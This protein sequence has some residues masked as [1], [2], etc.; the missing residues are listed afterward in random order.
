[1]DKSESQASA[2]T[3]SH[4]TVDQVWQE[5]IRAARGKDKGFPFSIPSICCLQLQG[6]DGRLHPP[7]ES[8]FTLWGDDKG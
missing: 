2:G 6:M 5:Q 7:T 1:M 4:G 3:M 8:R